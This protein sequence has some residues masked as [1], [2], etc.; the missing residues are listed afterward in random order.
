HLARRAIDAGGEHLVAV[1]GGRRQPDLVAPDD[2]RRPAAVVDGGLPDDVLALA[3]PDGELLRVGV[4]V[5]GRPTEARP[6]VPAEGGGGQGEGREQ[7]GSNSHGDLP[8]CR[9]R[10]EGGSGGSA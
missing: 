7:D 5:T 3:P 1:F 9:G 4:A 10:R 2:R 8:R 6:G